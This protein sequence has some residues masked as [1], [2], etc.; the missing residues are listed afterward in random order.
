M[1]ESLT[2]VSLGSS[3]GGAGTVDNGVGDRV[4]VGE[5][6]IGVSGVSA[7]SGVREGVAAAET[8]VGKGAGKSIGAWTVGVA[9]GSSLA[10]GIGVLVTLRSRPSSSATASGGQYG[11]AS[12]AQG[13]KDP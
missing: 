13:A 2:V 5:A 4:G 6:R 3:G 12:R 1:I 8:T 11:W 9:V 10:S 7:A